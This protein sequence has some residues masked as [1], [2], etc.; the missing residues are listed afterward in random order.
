[1]H[2]FVPISLER[3]VALHLKGNP[4][5]NGRLLRQSLEE[6]VRAKRA[7]KLCTCGNPIWAIGSA[8]VGHACFTCITGE[9]DASKDYEIDTSMSPSGARRDRSLVPQGDQRVDTG[10]AGRGDGNSDRRD[11]EHDT[12]ARE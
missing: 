1:M 5:E 3:F 8:F 2:R 11:R 7:G 9:A 4:G 12:G 10:R 6:A